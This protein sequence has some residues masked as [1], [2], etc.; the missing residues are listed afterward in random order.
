M[1][2]ITYRI[3]TCTNAWRK[4]ATLQ[5]LPGN[6]GPLEGDA[7]KVGGFSLVAGV[8]VQAHESQKLACLCRYFSPAISEKRLSLSPL[9][10][11]RY[12]HKAP[13]RNSSTH[14]EAARSADYGRALPHVHSRIE[15]AHLALPACSSG[16]MTAVYNPRRSIFSERL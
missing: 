14:V 16:T 4:V 8:A 2:S 12:P 9:G 11:V 13:W 3:A 10:R 6:A 5:T 15:V 1:S 7:S